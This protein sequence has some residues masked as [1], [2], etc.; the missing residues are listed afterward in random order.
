MELFLQSKKYQLSFYDQISPISYVKHLVGLQDFLT[1]SAV[2]IDT[3]L[4]K[5]FQ[6]FLQRVRHHGH[7]ILQKSLC[8]LHSPSYR[9][10]K[11]LPLIFQKTFSAI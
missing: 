5:K 6:N 3:F 8:L 2:Q 7:T 4:L 1:L 9:L 11:Q 10:R